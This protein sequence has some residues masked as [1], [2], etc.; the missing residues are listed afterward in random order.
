VLR[1]ELQTFL[2][3]TGGSRHQSLKNIVIVFLFFL[4][5]SHLYVQPHNFVLGTN[6]FLNEIRV[7]VFS[8][9]SFR[10]NGFPFLPSSVVLG[11]SAK[12][13]YFIKHVMPNEITS[14]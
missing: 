10:P 12:R 3:F 11:T 13:K 1:K 7:F 2:S 8:W 5:T 14:Q 9:L 6:A 4:T